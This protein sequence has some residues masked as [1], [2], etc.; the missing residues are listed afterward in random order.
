MAGQPDRDAMRAQPS[1]PRLATAARVSRALLALLLATL[2]P[3]GGAQEAGYQLGTSASVA[4]QPLQELIKKR[5]PKGP[6]YIALPRALVMVREGANRR[7]RCAPQVLVTNS[8]NQTIEELVAGIRYTKTDAKAAH[9]AGSTLARF[10]LLRVGK[11]ELHYLADA[12]EVDDCANLSAEVEILHCAY[13]SGAACNDDV[14]AVA[15]GA[16]PMTLI[17]K[18]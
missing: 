2:L 8:S 15:Y 14:R 16:I 1:H 9:N 12:L 18:K 3:A 10:H 5:R 4:A 7:P 11:E 6:I 13:D 17:E